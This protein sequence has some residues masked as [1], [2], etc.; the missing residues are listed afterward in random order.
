MGALIST[1]LSFFTGGI[2]TFF[3]WALK[4]WRLM[5]G[6][7]V[8]AAI[9]I[10]FWVVVLERNSARAQVA[11]DAT[12]IHTLTDQK[13]AL[14]SNVDLLTG[15]IKKQNESILTMRNDA[16]TAQAASTKAAQAAA[17]RN[18]KDA[19]TIAALQKLGTDKSNTG[20]CD[21]E[22]SRIRAGL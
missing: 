4:H 16:A 6:L 19:G 8:V 7:I 9:G 15:E 13:A 5:L 2:S 17:E 14:Q 18:K 10:S 12:T 22:I 1:A 20:S 3:T 21:A 11:A